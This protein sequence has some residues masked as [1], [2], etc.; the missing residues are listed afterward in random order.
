MD[1]KIN[2]I[3]VDSDESLHNAYQSIQ[4]H[5]VIAL[6]TEFVRIR[7][8]YPKLGLLQLFDGEQVYLIDPSGL[9][10]SQPIIDLLQDKKIIKVLHA[11]GEDLDIFYHYFKQMPEP[12]FDTQ[13]MSAFLGLGSSIGFSKLVENYC[14]IQLDKSTSRTDWLARPLSE[15]QLQYAAAD[16]WFLL[17][18]YQK[19]ME[20]LKT[21]EWLNAVN[22]ECEKLKIKRQKEITPEKAYKHIGNAWQLEPQQLAILQVLEKWRVEE[23][24]KRDLALNFIVK[25]ASLWK[26]AKDQ[27]KH[28]AQLLEFMHPNEVR[29]YGKKLLL[30]VEQAKHIP[31][32]LFPA[33]I[34]RLMDVP[35]YKKDMQFLKK[36]VLAVKPESLPIEVFCSKRQLEQ[37]FKW[38]NVYKTNHTVPELL[39]GWRK[40]FGDELYRQYLDYL[41]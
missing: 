39:S 8:Y 29:V 12:M 2:F 27:P 14:H 26:I 19:L 10:N 28:T 31:E 38:H 21:T 35:N 32:E 33:K 9:S 41:K 1:N 36:V 4:D 23:A 13:I 18:I 11:C 34:S 5:K 20:Q 30:M 6:D 7:S 22:E 37:L 15:K 17:P 24:K 25:E 40:P 3:W 16:V